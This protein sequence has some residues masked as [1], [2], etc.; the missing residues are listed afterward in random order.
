MNLKIS[1]SDEKLLNFLAALLSC[2]VIILTTGITV[3]NPLT[4]VLFVCIFLGL[5]YIAGF[6][7][8]KKPG[9]M[10]VLLSEALPVV[11]SGLLAWL[12]YPGISERFTSSAFKLITFAVLFLGFFMLIT[13]SLRIG[14]FLLR[15]KDFLKDWEKEEY[16]KSYA[17]KL[18][19]KAEKKLFA[20]TAGFCFLCYLP[21]FLYEFPGIMTAD[22]LVQYGEI[23]G[24]EPLTNHHPVV[25]TALIAVF[26]RLGMALTRNRIVSIS[27]YTVFQVLFLSLCCATAVVEITRI[28]GCYHK[29]RT[30]LNILFFAIMPFN[31][32]F[33]VTIWKDVPFAGLAVLF[34][35]HLV[36]MYRKRDEGITFTDLAVFV[37]LAVLF[38][39]FRSNGWIAFMAF[40]PF[41][42][43]TFRKNISKA[44]AGALISVV[45]VLI[46][47]GPVFGMLGIPG[48][49][50]V[51]SL[52][53]P[54]QH[55]ARVLV[56][57]GNVDSDELAMIDECIDRTYI[58]ELYVPGYADN[59]KELVRAG[60]PQAIE[61]DKKGYL[62]LWLRLFVKNPGLYIRAFYDLEGG[63]FYPDVQYSVA[64]ADGIQANDLG[65]YSS[66]IIGGRFIKVKEI[67]LKLSDFMPVYG[68]LFSIGMYTIGL[69]LCLVVAVKNKNMILIHILMLLI[70]GTL[71][72]AAPVMDFRYAYSLVLTMPVWGALSFSNNSIVK[73]D[74]N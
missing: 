65:L 4:V 64:E 53:L 60:N 47:K 39:L 17:I 62:G 32:V 1:F 7:Y 57:D 35:C 11:G 41:F 3:R 73:G 25:H 18:D 48:P 26:Y 67:L 12:L 6:T 20:F 2:W 36:E 24:T 10:L 74:N 8:K 46:V 42:L 19:D 22:S 14:F 51:E 45:L 72:V 58:K 15:K 37:L 59:I 28:E 55:V 40:I 5:D 38:S 13:S 56:E 30:I 23:L 63:Y 50:M 34:A 52:S 71:L 27:F 70:I 61:N 31:A 54:L 43:W 69:V 33:A 68:W 29:N 66:P 9:R 21:Y 49:D 16:R 44:T